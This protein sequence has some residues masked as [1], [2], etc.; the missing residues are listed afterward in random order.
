[1][2]LTAFC[3]VVVISTDRQTQNAQFKSWS[4]HFSFFPTLLKSKLPKRTTI[5][6]LLVGSNPPLLQNSR[7]SYEKF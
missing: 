4:K 3:I 1:M 7:L 5:Q 2:K 6:K